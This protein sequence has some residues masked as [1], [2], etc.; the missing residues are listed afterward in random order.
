M[1]TAGHQSHLVDL[2]IINATQTSTM[3]FDT[4]AITYPCPFMGVVAWQDGYP[5]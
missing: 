2:T 5:S 4:A 1:A 3:K